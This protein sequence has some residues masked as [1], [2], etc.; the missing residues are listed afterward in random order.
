MKCP[1]CGKRVSSTVRVCQ[2]CGKRLARPKKE[3]KPKIKIPHL[4][5]LPTSKLLTAGIV[6]LVI[7]IALVLAMFP[8]GG[9]REEGARL[10]RPGEEINIER[11]KSSREIATNA[12]YGKVMATHLRAN[13]RGTMTVRSL[14]TGKVYTFSVGWHTSYHPQRHPS[15]GE[16]STVHYLS[17]GEDLMKATQVKMNQ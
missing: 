1:K 10:E 12:V 15:I 9:K 6:G 14:H 2:H 7:L 8:G 13:R 17:E 3:T 5:Q 16:M 11:G 4:A